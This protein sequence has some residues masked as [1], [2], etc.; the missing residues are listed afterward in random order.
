MITEKIGRNL[1]LIIIIMKII[2]IIIQVVMK[3]ILKI[4]ILILNYHLIM[5]FNNTLFHQL[6]K[7]LENKRPFI[8]VPKNKRFWVRIKIFF[9]R[10]GKLRKNRQC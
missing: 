1:I 3:K 2:I 7:I 5:V 4:N 10:L 9:L 8:K 6:I